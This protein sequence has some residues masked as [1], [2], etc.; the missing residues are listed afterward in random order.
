MPAHDAYDRLERIFAYHARLHEHGLDKNAYLLFP[1]NF[2]RGITKYGGLPVTRADVAE[3]ML[4]T[5]PEKPERWR[6][7]GETKHVQPRAVHIF[8]GDESV[9]LM[10]TPEHAER[11]VDAVN[12]YEERE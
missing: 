8:E 4:A 9:G 5:A 2:M 6:V 1:Y 11:V 3:P 10:W 7:G 12:A